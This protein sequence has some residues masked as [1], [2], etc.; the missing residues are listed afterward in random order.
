MSIAWTNFRDRSVGQAARRGSARARAGGLAGIGIGSRVGAGRGDGDPA[1]RRA[2]PRPQSRSDGQALR[3]GSRLGAGGDGR[4]ARESDAQCRRGLPGPARKPFPERFVERGRT[5]RVQRAS[6]LSLRRRWQASQAP[7]RRQRG[8]LDL[9]APAV[10]CGARAQLRRAL[11]LSRRVAD[12]GRPRPRPPPAR[13]TRERRGDQRGARARRGPR[14]VGADA[15]AAR[16]PPGGGRDP[17]VRARAVQG[18]DCAR[19]PARVPGR[20]SAGRCTG[21]DSGRPDRA[22]DR[23]AAR[24]SGRRTS[25]P[26]RPRAGT[27]AGRC[28]HLP[29]ARPRGDG[30]GRRRP[31]PPP[32]GLRERRFP[33]FLPE[34][35]AAGVRPQSG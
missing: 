1:G 10:E 29:A 24:G 13:D 18:P 11:G 15:D 6:R 26:A 34:R 31:V 20:C 35:H 4:S 21:T 7:G 28:G 30:P 19:S 5:A 27:R 32:D 23:S 3:R 14:R 12:R 33:R 17:P 22:R 8:P 25:G 2:G 9:G 16:R